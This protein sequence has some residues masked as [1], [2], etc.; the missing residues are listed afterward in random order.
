M[1]QLETVFRLHQL[2]LTTPRRVL[3]RALET[4]HTPQLIHQLV[5]S[6]PNIDRTSIYRSLELFASL[7]II[8]VIPVGF[9]RKYELAEPFVP[10]HHH[11]NCTVC[12]STTPIDTPELE[13]LIASIAQ[14]HDFTVN[15][16]HFEL[17]GVCKQCRVASQ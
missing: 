5:A 3:F 15:A 11:V 4:A 16:H 17:E 1:E 8:H 7:G 14:S 12:G 6:C 2:R 13:Q 10:H 9:K